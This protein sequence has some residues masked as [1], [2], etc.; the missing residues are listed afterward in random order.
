MMFTVGFFTFFE[1]TFSFLE[2]RSLVGG[3]PTLDF[4]TFFDTNA[5]SV[6][7]L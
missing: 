3:F 4:F 2:I 1:G 6:A 5:A 7:L